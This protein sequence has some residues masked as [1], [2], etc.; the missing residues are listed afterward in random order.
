MIVVLTVH[1]R[2][3]VAV[4][5]IAPSRASRT[6]YCENNAA[7]YYVTH[8]FGYIFIVYY[9]R[10]RVTEPNV[11]TLLFWMV[12]AGFIVSYTLHFVSIT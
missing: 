6:H 10:M 11:E 7:K 3:M 12:I 1:A 5:S 8:C 9:V 4:A 2:S